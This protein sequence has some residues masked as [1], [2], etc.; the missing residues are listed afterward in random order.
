MGN[1]CLPILSDAIALQSYGMTEEHAQ[2]TA[3]R[4]M[5]L[6]NGSFGSCMQRFNQVGRHVFLGFATLSIRT[7]DANAMQRLAAWAEYGGPL[8]DTSHLQ[9]D[10]SATTPSSLHEDIGMESAPLLSNIDAAETLPLYKKNDA[11]LRKRRLNL[12][13]NDPELTQICTQ[14][15]DSLLAF[16]DVGT[17]AL[18][19]FGYATLTSVDIR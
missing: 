13:T 17:Q 4:A 15:F 14:I 3:G 1:M 9:L 10:Y 7:Y 2:I 18:V 12:N 6:Y 5:Y 19:A 16:L 8:P 11:G